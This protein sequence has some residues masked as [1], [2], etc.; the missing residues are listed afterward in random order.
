MKTNRAWFVQKVVFK[1]VDSIIKFG[2]WV[3]LI[4]GLGIAICSNLLLNHIMISY[5]SFV[6]QSLIGLSGSLQINSSP[7]M[8]KLFLEESEEENKDLSYSFLWDS[9]IPLHMILK[10]DSQEWERQVRVIV[11]EKSYL[12]NKLKNNTNCDFSKTNKHTALG[13]KWLFYYLMDLKR[14]TEIEVSSVSLGELIVQLPSSED[15]SC[16]LDTG[17]MVDYPILFLTWEI[18]DKKPLQWG[19]KAA[20]EYFILNP[21]VA[22]QKKTKFNEKLKKLSEEYAAEIS[23]KVRRFKVSNIFDDSEDLKMAK[24]VTE[25]AKLLAGVI[26]FITAVLIIAI[27][28][29]GFSML[30]ELKLKV[31]EIVNML[32]VDRNDIALAFFDKGRFYWFFGGCY[33]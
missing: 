18:I 13:N 25:Q 14:D 31:I 23:D 32:G 10:Q 19:D 33:R 20:L 28:T 6:Q 5:R 15:N 21:E 27:L 29:F 24:N 7:K 4:F 22:S 9:K 12:I 2:I 1:E 26:L 3:G 11:L 17:M 16:D 8:I 30:K